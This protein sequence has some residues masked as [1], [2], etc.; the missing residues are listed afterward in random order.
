MVVKDLGIDSTACRRRRIAAQKHRQHKA[1]NRVKQLSKLR[2][3][4]GGVRLRLLKGSIH[5]AMLFGVEA[6]G[7]P[8]KRLR[9]LR[10]MLGRQTVFKVEG[11]DCHFQFSG[12]VEDPGLTVVLRQFRAVHKL[13]QQW[14][15]QLR[16]CL[17]EA[18]SLSLR[19]L[20]SD[21]YPWLTTVAHAN[22]ANHAFGYGLAV[23]RAQLMVIYL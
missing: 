14:P 7:L 2:I 3:P 10:L 4:L 20:E 9:I 11:L 23:A 17:E 15:H 12:K 13:F 21:R 18:W 1:Q 22:H 16:S 19:K 8:P 6:H 5:P